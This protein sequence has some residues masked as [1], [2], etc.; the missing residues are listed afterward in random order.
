MGT[1]ILIRHGRTPAN[2]QGIL[3]GRSPGVQL[4]EVGK[5][6]ALAL[7]EKFQNLNVKKVFASPLERT[8]E[9]AN[10][11]FPNHQIE[12]V[13]DLIECEYGDWTGRKLS[14]LSNEPLWKDVQATP[15]LVTFPNGES[16]SAMSKRAVSAVAKIDED[17]TQVHGDEF[18]WAAISHGDIIKA[19]IANSLGL[20]LSKFQKIYVEPASVSVIRFKDNDSAVVKVNDTGNSWVEQLEKIAEPTLGGQSGSTT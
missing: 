13:S 11:V 7:Q 2:E 14:E 15:D 12:T 10:L 6:T 4:D 17:L 20:E 5:S 19:I 3:A 1:L 9:T 8:I 16:M 18:I